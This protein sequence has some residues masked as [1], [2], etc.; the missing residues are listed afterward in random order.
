MVPVWI[1][2]PPRGNPVPSTQE[3]TPAIISLDAPPASYRWQVGNAID[4]G[5]TP[6]ELMGVVRAAAPQAGRPRIVAAARR[7]SLMLALG[8]ARPG[9]V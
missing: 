2:G 6:E 9:T 8:L 4:A 1:A 3:R 5:A 7:L